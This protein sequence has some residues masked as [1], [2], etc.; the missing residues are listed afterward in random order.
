MLAAT[1]YSSRV[2]TSSTYSEDDSSGICSACDDTGSVVEELLFRELFFIVS[3]TKSIFFFSTKYRWILSSRTLPF[4][5]LQG[6]DK[7]SRCFLSLCATCRGLGAMALH[8]NGA[9]KSLRLSLCL[10]WV[11]YLDSCSSLMLL[12]GKPQT[13]P[14]KRR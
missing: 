14:P 10:M 1:E 3:S 6:R 12:S 5:K 7:V 13:C 4:M 8:P 9:T 2:S 11:I